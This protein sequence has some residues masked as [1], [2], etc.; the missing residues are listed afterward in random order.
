M[1]E[2][3]SSRLGFLMLAAGCAV[4][5][6]NVWRFSFI[7]GRNGGAAFVV[8][9]L[10][11]L[12]VLGFPALVAE[13]AIGRGGGLGIA[14]ALKAL[15]PSGTRRF[16]G[17]LGAV[18]FFGN[19]LLMIYYTDVAGWL[20]RYACDYAAGCPPADAAAAFPAIV[21]DHVSC[22]AYM[23]AT[24]GAATLVCMAGVVGGVER[25]CKILMLALVALLVVLA[26][27]AVSLPGAEKGL[28]FYLKPDW[29]VVAAHPWRVC[30]DALGQAFFTLS[31]GVGAMAIFGSYVG[32]DRSLVTEAAWIVA[33]DTAVA[34][35]SGLVVFPACAAYG[36]DYAE[37]P[38]L[39]FVALPKVFAKMPCGR[40][41][42][43]AFFLFLVF[44]ALSTV[45]AVFECI[46]GG[47]IDALGAR[48]WKVALAVGAAVAACSM[49]C[50]LFDS[51]LDWE[52]FAVSKVWLPCGA[53][54]MCLFVTR[55]IGWGWDGFR[56]EASAGKGGA[57][58]EWTRFHF[59]YVMPALILVVLL[60]GLFS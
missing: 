9:Y 25:V 10:V 16:W 6:G 45:I 29:S 4:G 11:F 60:G 54:A 24:V 20:V 22:A 32:R 53:L 26:V 2:R 48:R 30:F 31:I 42:G 44:A 58:P 8:V 28:E 5:L 19:F 37:G 14:G 50:V 13:L 27:K 38:S 51:V 59:A 23:A 33:I 46:I 12:A 3:L 56:A 15:A 39:I 21:A 49:P 1:R 57:L 34:L 18:V 43:L 17:R 40:V 7:A 47:M 36:V 52:D 41:W 55:G 35:M